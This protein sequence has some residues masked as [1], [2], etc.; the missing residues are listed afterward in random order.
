M[1]ALA[2]NYGVISDPFALDV[3]HLICAERNCR[4]R[5]QRG[6]C[7]VTDDPLPHECSPNN[8]VEIVDTARDRARTSSAAELGFAGLTVTGLD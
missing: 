6:D 5:N 4:A 7:E 2:H 8:Q 3:G 1:P